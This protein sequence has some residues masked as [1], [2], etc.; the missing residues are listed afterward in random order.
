MYTLLLLSFTNAAA[1]LGSTCWGQVYYYRSWGD[2]LA[3]DVRTSGAISSGFRYRPQPLDERPIYTSV[4]PCRLNGVP[5]S[6]DAAQFWDSHRINF[7]AQCARVNGRP[8]INYAAVV[9]NYSF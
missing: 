5:L 9:Y 7:V 3:L 2:V 8:V 4:D 6:V 1:C